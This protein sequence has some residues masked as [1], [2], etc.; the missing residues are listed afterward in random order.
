MTRAHADGHAAL[1]AALALEETEDR[2]RHTEALRRLELEGEASLAAVVS[3]SRARLDELARR[4]L[5][6]VV[7]GGATDAEARSRPRIEP[8]R[9]ARSDARLDPR[10]EARSESRKDAGRP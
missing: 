3:P 9:E 2:A 5:A 4:A 8:S 7:S 1:E 6:I 10:S